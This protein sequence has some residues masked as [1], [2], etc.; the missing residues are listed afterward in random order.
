ML[1]KLI[2]YELKATSR[3]FL[4]LYLTL[5]IVS[6]L[7][8]VFFN[9]P[10]TGEGSFS[11]S[12]LAMG[13]S[14]LV[15]VT[16]IVGMILMTLIVL[17]QRFYKNLLGDEGYLMFTL[18]VQSWSHII[19]KLA[20]SMFWIIISG[21]IALCSILIISAKNISAADISKGLSM[22][23]NQF[24]QYFGAY[25]FLTGFQIVLFGLLA[26]ASTILTVYAAIALGH[27]FNKHKVLASFG[28]YIALKTVSQ[29]LMTLFSAA[30][31]SGRN[32]RL[33]FGNMP[34]IAQINS[35]LMASI[36]YC[37]LIT[38]CY[39]VLTNYILKKKLNLE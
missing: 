7:N 21:I 19:S 34:D 31:F 17:I 20:V 37:G 22:V 32:F 1:G 13:I 18:P 4:P 11:I 16:L 14:M 9:V 23:I 12:N 30:F 15:Y 10:D 35:F 24:Q 8:L 2:K 5:V 6:L 25:S 26:L 3:F 36:I 27:L 29:I 33:A 38:T 39:F 28:M